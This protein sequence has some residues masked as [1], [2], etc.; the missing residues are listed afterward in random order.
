[1]G[2][3]TIHGKYTYIQLICKVNVGK[4]TPYMDPMGIGG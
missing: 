2:K 4:Y 3:Y 1:M